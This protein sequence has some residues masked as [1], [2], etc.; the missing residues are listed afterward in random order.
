[1]EEE[2]TTAQIVA[3]ET[4]KKTETPVKAKAEPEVVDTT[5]EEEEVVAES[6]PEG[7]EESEPESKP[8]SKLDDDEQSRVDKRFDKITKEKFDAIRDAEYWKQK[9]EQTVEP[10][11]P[12]EP[13]Q[14][15]KTLADFDY[16]EGKFAEH[17][18]AEAVASARQAVES[19]KQS[20]SVA[21]RGADFAGREAEF[22]E[23]VDDY[24]TVA[25]NPEL[26]ITPEMRDV[27]MESDQ[28]PQ[29]AYYLGN[30]PDIASKLSQMSP[31]SMAKE[32]GRIEA[33][34]LVTPASSTTNAPAPPPKIS[35]SA[36]STTVKASNAASDKM[37]DEAWLKSREKQV[38]Q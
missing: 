16:D 17:I 11:K 5:V 12:A 37:S 30:N 25:H 34:K 38:S 32:I 21:Q 18:T 19:E 33:T 20:D 28:G 3:E 1:M 13:V 29:L 14:L 2:V 31:L 7:E 24:N 8:H 6:E 15:T 9:A 35:G 36:P 4:A 27:V 26:P 10:V 22:K 23:T